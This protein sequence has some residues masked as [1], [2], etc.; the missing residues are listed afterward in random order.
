MSDAVPYLSLVIPA[1]N[2]EGRLGPTLERVLTFFQ[3]RPYATEVIVVSD[4]SQ[5]ATCRVAES[6]FA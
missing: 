4:G 3:E 1:F 2:E 6:A 5:D